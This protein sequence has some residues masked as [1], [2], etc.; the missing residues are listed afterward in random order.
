MKT[1]EEIATET[2]R[3]QTI[4]T[5]EDGS[6][7]FSKTE[8]I[9]AKVACDTF[10]NEHTIANLNELNDAVNACS[11]LPKF[12]ELKAAIDNIYAEI[13]SQLKVQQIQQNLQRLEAYA[14]RCFAQQE[15]ADPTV[16]EHV[17][18]ANMA[19]KIFMSEQTSANYENFKT[20]LRPC[21]D[22]NIEGFSDVYKALKH[23]SP[24]KDHVH[25]KHRP[26]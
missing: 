25:K 9:K 18:N 21:I 3:A 20:A 2:F 11:M 23:L 10:I 12:D 17:A 16:N 14:S 19:Y 5:L 4:T 6:I 26:R 1:L 13:N 22:N 7:T 8:V 15:Q 24:N